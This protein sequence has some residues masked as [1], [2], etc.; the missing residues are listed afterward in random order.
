MDRNGAWRDLC[1]GSFHCLLGLA[2]ATPGQAGA[3]PFVERA[4]RLLGRVARGWEGRRARRFVV[5]FCGR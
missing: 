5:R 2:G 1:P 4:A 3:D